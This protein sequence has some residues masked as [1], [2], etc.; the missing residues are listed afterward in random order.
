MFKYAD[1]DRVMK[2]GGGKVAE[3]V[4]IIERLSALGA[5]GVATEGNSDSTQNGD[6]TS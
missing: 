6:S 5:H 1:M 4:D 2:I 3:I